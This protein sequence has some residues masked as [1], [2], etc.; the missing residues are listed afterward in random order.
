MQHHKRAH[1]ESVNVVKRAQRVIR[2]THTD[3]V[4]KRR[5]LQDC[6]SSDSDLV[7]FHVYPSVN[8]G[9]IESLA[10]SFFS[11]SI[12]FSSVDLNFMKSDKHEIQNVGKYAHNGKFIFEF[13]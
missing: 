1:C 2:H 5:S 8:K 13:D 6:D 10:I 3:K 11:F 7:I 9:P 4:W 12:N